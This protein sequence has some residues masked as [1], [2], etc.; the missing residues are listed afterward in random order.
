MAE[1]HPALIRAI[2][3]IGTAGDLAAKIGI[4]PQALSQWK[5]VPATRVLDVERITGIP[6]QELRPDIYGPQPALA[7]EPAA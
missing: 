7:Q 5:Q 4:T 1:K 3:V 6:R 2:D